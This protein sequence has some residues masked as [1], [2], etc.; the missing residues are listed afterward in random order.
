M[1]SELVGALGEGAIIL[2]AKADDWRHAV[3]LAGDA[4]VAAGTTTHAY[5]EAMIAAI[6][7]LG[8]YIVI[9]PGIAL[10]HARPSEAVLSTGLSWVGL[11]QPVEFGHQSND[12]VD[13]VIG[14]AATDHDGHLEVMSSLAGVLADP[15][16]MARLRAATEP[17]QVREL[18]AEMTG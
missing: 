13:L 8:P 18:L 7:E 15:D 5:T 1:T 4:L 6:D 17:R 9:A 11:S 2:G 12:P 14:L 3:T 10:A 16:H